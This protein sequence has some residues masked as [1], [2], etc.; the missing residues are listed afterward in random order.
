M[1]GIGQDRHGEL[2][3]LGKSGATFGPPPNTGITDPTN[4]SGVVLRLAEADDDDHD[5]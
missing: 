4:T 1:L 3:V 2:Y 5:D